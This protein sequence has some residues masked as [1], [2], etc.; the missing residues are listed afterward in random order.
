M[1]PVMGLFST[2][3]KPAGPKPL[4][5]NALLGQ[6]VDRR[7]DALYDRVRLRCGQWMPC[8]IP[9]FCVPVGQ[10]D[11]LNMPHL[12]YFNDTN[13]V[14]AGM[15][16]VPHDMIIS[17]HLLLFQPTTSEV[18]RNRFVESYGWR[19][20]IMQKIFAQQPGL[21][22][23]AQGEVAEVMENFGKGSWLDDHGPREND[24]ASL[25]SRV[26]KGLTY[27]LGDFSRYL[28]PQCSFYFLLAGDPFQLQADF[29][30]YV[31]LDG[32]RDVPAQ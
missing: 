21:V 32:S 25:I 3:T 31:M 29:D 2:K 15:L 5:I 26:A 17:K 7:R 14:I 20:G 28:P 27:D 10:P 13:M 19:F 22:A 12:K 16:P 30:M 1:L 8:N 24:S 9:L 4:D 23:A 6:I 11:P 18:D